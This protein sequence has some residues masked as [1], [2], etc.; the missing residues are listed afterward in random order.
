MDKQKEYESLV[1]IS[2]HARLLMAHSDNMDILYSAERIEPHT[3]HCIGSLGYS[4]DKFKQDVIARY[5]E[6]NNSLK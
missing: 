2:A 6:L 4:K 3:L 1:E 5:L